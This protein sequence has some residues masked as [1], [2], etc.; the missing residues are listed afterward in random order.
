MNQEIQDTDLEMYS[1][2]MKS[3]G[4]FTSEYRLPGLLSF[5]PFIFG[6]VYGYK[7]DSSLIMGISFLAMIITGFVWNYIS[8]KKGASCFWCKLKMRAY[9]YIKNG[10]SSGD[11]A[12]VCHHCKKYFIWG[13]NE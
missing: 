5:F 1:E 10:K 6:F 7:E 4:A 3:M 8:Y 9:S 13:S 2:D 12:Y 11:A